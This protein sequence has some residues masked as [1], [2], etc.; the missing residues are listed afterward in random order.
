MS[1]IMERMQIS[2][3]LSKWAGKEK[4]VK[5]CVQSEVTTLIKVNDFNVR[6][7]MLLFMY[8]LDNLVNNDM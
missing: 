5:H 4:Q 1:L 7:G 6:C 2:H 8:F 3:R